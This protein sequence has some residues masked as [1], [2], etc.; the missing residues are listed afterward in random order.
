L[1]R[2]GAAVLAQGRLGDAA[3]LLAEALTIAERYADLRGISR[4]HNQLGYL[5]LR[6]AALDTARQHWHTALDMAWRVP[7]RTHLLVTLDV[8]MGLIARGFFNRY[9]FLT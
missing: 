4:A 2:V 8:L 7:D 6:Q 1:S 5:A 3:T 9:S